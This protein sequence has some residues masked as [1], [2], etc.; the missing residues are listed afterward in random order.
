MQLATLEQVNKLVPLVQRQLNLDVI[1]LLDQ[2]ELLVLVLVRTV[3][4]CH[5]VEVVVFLVGVLAVAV[6]Q[7]AEVLHGELVPAEAV[8]E[9]QV[10]VKQVLL[11]AERARLVNEIVALDCLQEGE[12]EALLHL[13]RDRVGLVGVSDEIGFWN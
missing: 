9:H 5:L 11:L 6:N 8:E 10:R 12:D 13:A 3:V 7:E 2:Y 4:G 1:A